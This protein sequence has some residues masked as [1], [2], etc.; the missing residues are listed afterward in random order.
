MKLRD[1]K[2]IKKKKKLDIK[3]RELKDLVQE[4]EDLDFE[5]VICGD[6]KT[7]YQY[8]DVRPDDY[9]LT[10]AELLFADDKILNKMISVKKIQA[11]KDELTPIDRNN[12]RK[13]RALVK[14]SA[15]RNQEKYRKELEIIAEGERLKKLSK[16]GGKYKKQYEKY[17]LTQDERIKEIYAD[18]YW[19]NE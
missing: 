10:D 9:G 19:E 1:F 18:K 7:K 8:I 15:E 2:E 17:M 11:Y 13:N 3:D 4:Y 16:K 5:D 6:L 12:I 14:A